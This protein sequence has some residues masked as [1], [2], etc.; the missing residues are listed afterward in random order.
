MYY[1]KLIEVGF[2]GERTDESKGKSILVSRGNC[3]LLSFLGVACTDRPIFSC[4]IK[5]TLESDKS[6]EQLRLT[7]SRKLEIKRND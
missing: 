3:S 6:A 5:I 1:I 7:G 4:L 2:L